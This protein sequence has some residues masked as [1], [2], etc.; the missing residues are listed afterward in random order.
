[1]KNFR[2]TKNDMR[3]AGK[4]AI[5]AT[6]AMSTFGTVSGLMIGFADGVSQGLTGRH[7]E[8]GALTVATI[9]A[10]VAG[11]GAG[12]VAY[13][14]TDK[15]IMMI[16]EKYANEEIDEISDEDP[17]NEKETEEATEEAKDTDYLNGIIP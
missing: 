2:F 7:L 12:L 16:D 3:T 6:A 4:F 10:V 8:G 1:M 5:K 13:D 11:A 14:Y 15:A 9:P 17:L